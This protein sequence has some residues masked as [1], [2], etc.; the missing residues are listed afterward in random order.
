LLLF[1]ACRAGRATH[2]EPEKEDGSTVAIMRKDKETREE[3]EENPKEEGSKGTKGS[4]IASIRFGLVDI[5]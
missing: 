2:L 4:T 1:R 5:L 3:P